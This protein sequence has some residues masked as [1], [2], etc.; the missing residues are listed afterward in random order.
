MYAHLS[1]SYTYSHPR[2]TH[3]VSFPDHF[4]YRWEKYLCGGKWSGNETTTTHIHPYISTLMPHSVHISCTCFRIAMESIC[5]N[6]FVLSASWP[7]TILDGFARTRSPVVNARKREREYTNIFPTIWYSHVYK[8][9][10]AYKVCP[11][12][13][14][15]KQSLNPCPT[16][17]V[18]CL[19]YSIQPISPHPKHA[20]CVYVCSMYL[21]AFGI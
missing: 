7:D 18:D 19:W 8:M 17:K 10:T 13:S 3:L 15:R 2:F 4:Y 11:V 9:Y 12:P 21:N 6:S 20:Q 1:T 14:A 5:R 16:E